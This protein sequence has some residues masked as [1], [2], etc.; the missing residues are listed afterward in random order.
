MTSIRLGTRDLSAH[1]SRS[2]GVTVRAIA[3]LSVVATVTGLCVASALPE[4]SSAQVH[5][6]TPATTEDHGAEQSG[7]DQNPAEIE[8]SE[9]DTMLG[10]DW[11]SSDDIAWTSTGDQGGF[12]VLTA[13]MSEGYRWST[14][15]T[16]SIP[17]I[18]SDLWVGNA[19]MTS[20]KMTIAAVFAP[21]TF[22]ND[23]TLFLRGGYGALID[24]NTGTV[25]HLGQ[26]YALAHF[27]PSCGIDAQV[28]FSAYDA[29]LTKVTSIRTAEEEAP[30]ALDF[31]VPVTEAVATGA[32]LTAVLGNGLVTLHEDGG[33]EKLAESDGVPFDIQPLGDDGVAYLARHGDQTRVVAD[34]EGHGEAVDVV[35]T[36]SLDAVDLVR[37]P[38]GVV[39]VAGQTDAPVEQSVGIVQDDTVKP[40]S[41]LSSTDRLAVESTVAASADEMAPE[42]SSSTTPAIDVTATV[43]KTNA[44][45]DFT[46]DATPVPAATSEMPDAYLESGTQS[47]GITGGQASDPKS[48][49]TCAVPRNDPQILAQQ[50][51]PAE[52]EWAADQAVRG[53]LPVQATTFLRPNL[54]GG[55]RVPAQILLGVLAQESNF[56]QASKFAVPG[57]YGNPLVGN[58]FGTDR[59][60]TSP[61]AWWTIDFAEADCGY[62]IAQVTDG[63]RVG[64][65]SYAL[66]EAI[67]TDYQANIA[68]GLQILVEKWN[69][70]RSAGMLI[71]D[72]DPK[73]LENWFF[74][75][76]AYNTG[77]YPQSSSSEPWGVGWLNNPINPIYPANRG[78]FLDGDPADATHPQDWPYPERVLGFAANS[79]Y[80]IKEV[81]LTPLGHEYKYTTAFTPAWW[82]SS[83]GNQGE[84]NRTNVKPPI[85]QFC[86]DSN[87]C[88]PAASVTV[89]DIGYKVP[90]YHVHAATGL[91]DLHC[92]YNQPSTW[93]ADCASKCGYE[94]MSY[95][96][97]APKPARSTSFPSNCSASALP[98]GALII[99]DVPSGLPVVRPGCTPVPSSGTFQFDFASGSSG[100]YPSKIDTHQL[101]AGFNGHFWF[102]HTRME[103]QWNSHGGSLDVKG[104]WT[105]NQALNGWAQV[106]VHTPDHGAWLQQAKY[107]IDTGSGSSERIINQRNYANEWVPL[108]TLQFDGVPSIS[109]GNDSVAYPGEVRGALNGVDD[110]A[111]DAVAFVPLAHKPNE[112]IVSLGDSYSSGEGTS[113]AGGYDFFRGSD[114]DGGAPGNPHRNACH[115]SPYSWPSQMSLPSLSA[116]SVGGLAEDHDPRVDYQMLACAGAV[117]KNILAADDGGVGQYA[118][119]PQ[120][121]RGFLDANTTI[122]TLTI[123][124]N[125]IGFGPVLVECIKQTVIGATC[126]GLSTPNGE[127]DSLADQMPKRLSALTGKVTTALQAIHSKAPNAKILL[128]GYPKIFA[129]NAWCV[130]INDI[131]RDWLNK[132]AD[133]LNSS[134]TSA[135]GAAG[136]YVYYANP[137]YAF[138]GHTMCES[139]PGITALDTTMTPGDVPQ[140]LPDTPLALGASAQSIHPSRLGAWFYGN[141]AADL[142]SATRVALSA[143]IAGGA[144]TTYYSTFRLHSGGPASMNVSS[145]SSCGGELRV[146]LRKN[147][148][149]SSGVLG[150]QHTDSLSW[151][152]PS[153]FKNFKW[154]ADGSYNL[155]TGWYAM[156]VR[157]VNTCPSGSNQTWSGTLQW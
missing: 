136:S 145:F 156:N 32:G 17:G 77:F 70:T 79:A 49:G 37:G 95:A 135:A 72:G 151:A 89:P 155:P 140:F 115:R 21:R 101:G 38:S 54:V 52:V 117:T 97:G 91:Y 153:G 119:V 30:I 75:L 84:T 104:T 142:N 157:M 94:Y 14:L 50:P 103:G 98:A 36:G 132:V 123:G 88:D 87:D 143:G 28:T 86:D 9:R 96:L 40:A 16:L 2:A 130:F 64:E 93:K 154:T 65:M 108:G 82:T 11:E 59:S 105:L 63:M 131:S 100:T 53:A 34:L 12:H 111:W 20:D 44:P 129:G 106:Y 74:A 141:V 110:I 19:C 73:Y 23:E 127:S 133:G 42:G 22:T 148:A 107:V 41:T 33:L 7:D 25:K 92:W 3:L 66:Q 113:Q 116:V 48:I 69:Q 121:D 147:D 146:G 118:E 51:N 31:D 46:I 128:L 27:S 81:A 149:N 124:G 45:V 83:D 144:P 43:L 55:G 67:A 120:L 15:A 102:S 125:D 126:Q 138:E 5:S 112:F 24:V 61:N 8:Q 85:D 10:K 134:L 137:E 109:L 60:S 26:G 139:E 150:Q 6:E 90:C 57:V 56:W 13:A 78:S 29:G 35:A 152:S 68:R 114:H 58:Y 18:D 76:W 71:N 4:T 62:G 80:F 99:D 47:R 39:H 122:V 1:R